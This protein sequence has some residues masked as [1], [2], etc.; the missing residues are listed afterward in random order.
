MPSD[1]DFGGA[2]NF[3]LTNTTF[4]HV[5]GTQNNFNYGASQPNEAAPSARLNQCPSSQQSAYA[6]TRESSST[7]NSNNASN[8]TVPQTPNDYRRDPHTD[9]TGNSPAHSIAERSCRDEGIIHITSS[10]GAR[11]MLSPTSNSAGPPFEL[12]GPP[13]SLT[14]L[15]STPAAKHSKLSDNADSGQFLG[16]PTSTPPSPS[17]IKPLHQSQ[18]KPQTPPSSALGCPSSPHQ[19]HPIPALT[20][21]PTKISNSMPSIELVLPR[22][23]LE[24]RAYGTLPTLP[25]SVSSSTSHHPSAPCRLSSVNHGLPSQRLPE[26]IPQNN[27]GNP[28]SVQSTKPMQI[29]QSLASCQGSGFLSP[30]ACKTAVYSQR[31]L[32][33]QTSD[34]C[35]SP[36]PMSPRNNGTARHLPNCS[37]TSTPVSLAGRPGLPPSTSSSTQSGMLPLQRVGYETH[38]PE[39]HKSIIQNNSSLAPPPLSP[40]ILYSTP[41]IH[42][43]TTSGQYNPSHTAGHQDMYA[44]QIQTHAH[45]RQESHN[46]LWGPSEPQTTSSQPPQF[47]QPSTPQL[48]SPH[49]GPGAWTPAPNPILPVP[50][51]W[52]PQIPPGHDP[53]DRHM[54]N[55]YG[56]EAIPPPPHVHGG[57]G[58]WVPGMI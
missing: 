54:I 37:A 58:F 25:S 9:T 13:P 48:P 2:S 56:P 52:V 4:N 5:D 50:D 27:T 35:S 8:I 38:L 21:A 51:A 18:L 14:T 29:M 12:P 41:P 39:T 44:Q 19:P 30:V 20:L 36:L 11:S 49:H 6:S 1:F 7:Q 32:T 22:P 3:H 24:T 43:L 10:C 16:F 47:P 28:R 42:I 57:G 33:E 55:V 34:V 40:H 45:V 23:V 15:P 31:M 53:T 46:R 17:A 26:S